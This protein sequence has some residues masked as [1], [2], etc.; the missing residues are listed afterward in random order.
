MKKNIYAE[1]RE[2]DDYRRIMSAAKDNPIMAKMIQLEL[3]DAIEKRVLET[4]VVIGRGV[5]TG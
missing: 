5:I 3:A 4:K 1:I 2:S